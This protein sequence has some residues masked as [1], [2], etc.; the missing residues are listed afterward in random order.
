MFEFG[1]Q[2]LSLR[3]VQV[4]LI[5]VAGVGADSHQRIPAPHRVALF[6]KQPFDDAGAICGDLDLAAAGDYSPGYGHARLVFACNGNS[7]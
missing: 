7:G 5:C 4:C 6:E 2:N 1:K 3:I